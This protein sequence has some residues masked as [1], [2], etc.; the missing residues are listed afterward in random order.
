MR[1]TSILLVGMAALAMGCGKKHA[2]CEDATKH[3]LDLMVAE[4]PDSKGMRADMEK[5]LPD[6]IER[7]KKKGVPQEALDCVMEAKNQKDVDACEPKG[8][9]E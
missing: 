3:V 8:K 5:E 7:C 6:Q 2:T 4:A 9:K 1:K